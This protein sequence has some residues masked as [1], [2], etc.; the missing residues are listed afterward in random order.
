MWGYSL[1]GGR[2]DANPFRDLKYPECTERWFGISVTRDQKIQCGCGGLS[3][4]KN[5]VWHLQPGI[6]WTQGCHDV[7]AN[8]ELQRRCALLP[9]LPHLRSRGDMPIWSKHHRRTDGNGGEALVHRRML[10]IAGQCNNNLRR[11][12]GDGGAAKGGGVDFCGQL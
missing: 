3:G 4:K 5:N 10:P 2:A 6:V 11:G 9:Q 8:P 12:G 1:W 7:G